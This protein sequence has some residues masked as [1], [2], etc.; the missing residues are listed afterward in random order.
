LLELGEVFDTCRVTVNGRRLP[1]VSVL[2]PVV[3]VGPH[4]RRGA[5]TIEVEVATTLNNRLRVSDPGV[6]GGASRQNYGLIGPVRLV[7]YGE[8][9]VRTR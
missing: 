1:P 7:P 3:D 9:A 4:L 2:V 6:Y 8:A 5:N